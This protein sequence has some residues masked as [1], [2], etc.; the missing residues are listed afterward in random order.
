[1]KLSPPAKVQIAVSSLL[2]KPGVLTPQLR[3]AVEA[4]A[5]NLAGGE[6]EPQELPADMHEFIEKVVVSP[7]QV[8]ERDFERLGEA[9]Y[10]ED[11]IFEITLCASVGAGMARMERGLLALQGLA[12]GARVTDPEGK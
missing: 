5:A 11:A 9:G 1:M 10:S 12:V 7:H 3:Q 4:R 6:R 2:S 8:R